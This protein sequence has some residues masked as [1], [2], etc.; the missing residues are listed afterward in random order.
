MR[1]LA[2]VVALPLPA[3]A[4]ASTFEAAMLRS[5]NHARAEHH[6]RPFIPAK[7]LNW[8]ARA[9]SR[10][11]VARGY[12]AHD[13]PD[14]STPGSRTAAHH[15]R[16]RSFG[17]A[18]A[19]ADGTF[20]NPALIVAAWLAS[21]PHRRVLLGGYRNAGIGCVDGAPE[22]SFPPAVT[23]TLDAASPDR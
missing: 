20:A 8:A 4:A 13:S 7:R 2:V 1:T 15:Y 19:W 21:P 22:P 5:I 12:F 10:D 17:E 11:M 3:A 23:C 6:L 14:G 18:I 16:W 9:H